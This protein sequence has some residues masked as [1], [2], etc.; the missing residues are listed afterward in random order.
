MNIKAGFINILDCDAKVD[1]YS[2]DTEGINLAMKMMAANG[3]GTVIFPAGNIRI[4]SPIIIPDSGIRI[5]TASSYLTRITPLDNFEGDKILY[6]KNKRDG[7]KGIHIDDGL[8]INC[9]SKKAHGIYV[10]NGYD[11]FSFRNVEI[12]NLHP[13]YVGFHFVCEQSALTVGQTI[14]LE[15]CFVE[16]GSGVGNAACYSFDKYQEINLI[17][18]K[19][20]ANKANTKLDKVSE[21]SSTGFQFVDCR[22]VT[23][24]GCSAAFA[25]NAIVFTANTRN[26]IG[27]TV[28]GQTNESIADKALKTDAVG[29]L[30]VSHVTVLPIRAQNGTGKYDLNKLVL[31]TVFSSN[32]AVELN[33]SSFQNMIFTAL[34]EAVTGSTSKNTIITSANALK[35]G[36]TFNDCIEIDADENPNIV[37]K[38]KDQ[39]MIRVNYKNTGE[40][41]IQKYDMSTKIWS[42]TFKILPSFANNYTGLIVPYRVDGVNKMGQIKVGAI[43]SAG[44]GHRALMI[45]N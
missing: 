23:M 21:L 29:T 30:K 25:H 11:Q 8:F 7:N 26:A 22:G 28:M 19:A 10:E 42:D 44:T 12:R 27:L 24:T 38:N 13:D 9:N 34:K 2:D 32:E 39:A 20:F 45:P 31:S 5:Q 17:G 35:N 15:N 41:V 33:A 36:T 43:D 18:C 4:S 40:L 1:G 37:F 16:H 14:L 6:F 3:G